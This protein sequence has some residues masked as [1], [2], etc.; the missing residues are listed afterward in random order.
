M[1]YY[2]LVLSSNTREQ[3]AA[4]CDLRKIREK[5]LQTPHFRDTGKS[6]KR[7]IFTTKN[8]F[9]EENRTFFKENYTF[10]DFS[11]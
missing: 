9:Y 2:Y 11:A 10:F 1:R 6:C 5:H 8:D 3:C 7:A 4:K